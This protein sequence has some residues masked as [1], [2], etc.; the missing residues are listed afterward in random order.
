MPMCIEAAALYWVHERISFVTLGNYTFL[1]RKPRKSSNN[2][3][4]VLAIL[5]YSRSFPCVEF[6]ISV[7]PFSRVGGKPVLFLT[8]YV[9][10]Q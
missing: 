6:V 9:S 8:L 10:V 1:L 5:F 2:I 7:P 4:G 3:T